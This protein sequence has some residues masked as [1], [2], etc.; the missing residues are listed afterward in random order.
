M[1]IGEAQIEFKVEE[2]AREKLRG[3]NIGY[4][5]FVD[6]QTQKTNPLV[7]QTIT[8][9]SRTV[10][11]R[12]KDTTRIAD[13]A[14]I[15][16]IRALFSKVGLDPTKERPSGEAL[17]RRVVG[18]QGL[19]RINSVVD[20]N[21]VISLL[22]GCPCGVYDLAK[23]EGNTITILV[24]KPGDRYEGIGGKM[25]NAENRILTADDKSIFGGP[26][27]DSART[28]VTLETKEVLMLIYHPASAPMEVLKEAMQNAKTHMQ[29]ATGG[30]EECSGIYQIV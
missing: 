5:C 27:A 25:M 21:N 19:Y 2:A 6:A 9:A 16:G 8:A 26:T 4:C 7:D 22:S 13:D 3:L 17:I 15:K 23:I 29:R 28:C 20:I 24:G 1:K 18:G 14:V 10:A 30:R 12:Y 11:E